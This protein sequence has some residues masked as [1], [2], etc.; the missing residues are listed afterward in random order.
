MA[1]VTRSQ[2]LMFSAGAAALG[3]AALATLLAG[4]IVTLAGAGATAVDPSL[5][6]DPDFQV[7]QTPAATGPRNMMLLPVGEAPAP[8]AVAARPTPAEVLC[9]STA[10]STASR[11][12]RSSPQWARGYRRCVLLLTGAAAATWSRAGW[13]GRWRG[14]FLARVR[15]AAA[16]GALRVPQSGAM[17]SRF[18]SGRRTAVA[19]QRR[20]PSGRAGTSTGPARARPRGGPGRRRRG[21]TARGPASSAEPVPIRGRSGPACPAGRQGP[22]PRAARNRP[23]AT[24]APSSTARRGA[25][26]GRCRRR[27]PASSRRARRRR[28][29]QASR[30]ARRASGLSTP[31]PMSWSVSWLGEAS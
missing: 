9:S 25:P 6:F 14:V 4:S 7:C 19:S 12:A 16:P 30:M 18:S 23:T 26:A 8:G 15:S 2:R 31:Q 13:A 29:G 24:P 20:P 17:S 28:P 21:W 22:P 1:T 5:P 10:A 3:G 11:A 27:R